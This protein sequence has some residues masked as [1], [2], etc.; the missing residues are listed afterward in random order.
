MFHQTGSYP[1]WRACPST[2]FIS[3]RKWSGR[4]SAPASTPSRGWLLSS[5]RNLLSWTRRLVGKIRL[6]TRRLIN[7]LL[8]WTRR[9]VSKIRLWARRLINNLLSWARM[10]VSNILSW[11]KRIV[12]NLLSWT[13][14]LILLFS[15]VKEVSPAFKVFLERTRSLF[16]LF[17]NDSHGVYFTFWKIQFVRSHVAL[18]YFE[19]D[20]SSQQ[21]I[22]KC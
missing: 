3:P 17:G 8:S 4:T 19:L 12:S 9:L 5:A 18:N 10:V 21:M 22:V 2:W 6:W 20:I 15:K 11:T 1:R 13:S 14:R 16:S 7:N